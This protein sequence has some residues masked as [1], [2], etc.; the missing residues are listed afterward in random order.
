MFDSN[1][2]RDRSSNSRRCSFFPKLAL[3]SGRDRRWTGSYRVT[4]RNASNSLFPWNR[5]RVRRR[6]VVVVVTVSSHL[7]QLY[8]GECVDG[9]SQ[10]LSHSASKLPHVAGLLLHMRTIKNFY[11]T[12]ATPPACLF[13]TAPALAV[14]GENESLLRRNTGVR[15]AELSTY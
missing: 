10:S 4:Q 13:P 11:N 9:S 15:L 2:R 6:E 12:S 1:D 8:I 3:L 5:W 7:I 14:L